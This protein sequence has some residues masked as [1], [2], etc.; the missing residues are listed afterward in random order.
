MPEKHKR[1]TFSVY[2]I[3]AR[4]KWGTTVAV[5][6]GMTHDP[7]RRLRGHISRLKRA[8]AGDKS[9]EEP[10]QFLK[11]FTGDRLVF[12]ILAE[13]I[14]NQQLAYQRETAEIL[15]HRD[16]VRV[17]NRMEKISDEKMVRGLAYRVHKGLPEPRWVVS[18]PG[19]LVA[20]DEVIAWVDGKSSR[21]IVRLTEKREN[22][23]RERAG[24][25]VWY[26]EPTGIRWTHGQMPESVEDR[27]SRG[28][29]WTRLHP[30]N[31]V[32][33]LNAQAE[34]ERCEADQS[35]RRAS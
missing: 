30:A 23:R 19:E 31:E 15:R 14:K 7:E 20:G 1:W 6:I 12:E 16:M 27:V 3:R 18:V 22:E 2:R 25:A 29:S 13:G 10:Y 35:S 34:A 4:D 28:S 24:W 5:Y 17:L 26:F 33:A 11:D 8:L 9:I 21:G 32:A